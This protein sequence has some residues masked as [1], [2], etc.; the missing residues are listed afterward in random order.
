FTAPQRRVYDVVLAAQKA[1]IER[2]RPGA[3]VEDVHAGAREVLLE[4]LLRLG[5]LAG[6]PADL[7]AKNEDQRFSLHRTS[8]WLGRDVQ[9]RGRYTEADGTSRRLVPGM[10]LTVEPG[11]YFRLDEEGAP[12]ELRG[13]GVR[14]ED[15]VEITES[16]NRVLS[17]GAPK[18]VEELE[19]LVG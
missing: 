17:A 15:D 8:H 7:M 4:G 9:D 11:L 14:I 6:E 19:S 13:I 18:E 12:D 5:A 10:V 2:A 16:S 3:S 1:A